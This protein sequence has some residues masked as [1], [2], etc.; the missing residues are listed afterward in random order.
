MNFTGRKMYPDKIEPGYR[1]SVPVY[2]TA[3]EST[4]GGQA[5]Q[6]SPGGYRQSSKVHFKVL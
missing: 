4:A 2:C 1:A 5:C 3:P 6:P